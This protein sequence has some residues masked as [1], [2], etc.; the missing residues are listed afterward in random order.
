M[1]SFL[2][3]LANSELP[4]TRN[5]YEF[6]DK[7]ILISRSKHM[8]YYGFKATPLFLTSQPALAKH[9]QSGMEF[10]IKQRDEIPGIRRNNSKI[11]I[12]GVPSHSKVGLAREPDVGN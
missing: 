6:I 7:I 2:R 10:N 4:R 12:K 11:V 1:S 5:L 8:L 3:N 9:D